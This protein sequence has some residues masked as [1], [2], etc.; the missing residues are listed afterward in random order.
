MDLVELSKVK[1]EKF[2]RHPWEL[3]RAR[4][5]L[6]FLHKFISETST[7][8]DIGSGDAFIAKNTAVNFPHS[9]V[10]AVDKNYSGDIIQTLK[11]NSPKN[12]YFVSDISEIHQPTSSIDA[13]ILMD[14]IEHIA[15]PQNF[16]T[17][18]KSFTSI[19]HSSCFIITVPAF[20][21]LFSK[22]DTALGHYKRYSRKSLHKLMSSLGFK[23]QYSGYFFCTLLLIRFLQKNLNK[24]VSTEGL[25][26]WKGG[27]FITQ[28]I[29]G[30]F[31]IEFKIS[32]YLSRLKIYIP[33][34]TCYCICHRLPS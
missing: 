30:I 32:W 20:Q 11:Y 21:F 5:L 28:F 29:T 27:K 2:K 15:N 9:F 17:H 4:I 8:A 34:L 26:N 25:H 6:F 14:V 19:N 24:S 10:L 16:L 3:A 31:W 22:H 23:I 12:I 33:G 1:E 7:I 13:F 18:I